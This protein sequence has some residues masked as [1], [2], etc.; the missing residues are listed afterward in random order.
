ML[1]RGGPYAV[2]SNEDVVSVLERLRSL[3]DRGMDLYFADATTN[4][5]NLSLFDDAFLSISVCLGNTESLAMRQSGFA[6][7]QFS[8]HESEV[9]SCQKFVDR[10]LETANLATNGY[11]DQLINTAK[12]CIDI[13]EATQYRSRS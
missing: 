4:E 11:V 7:I 5:A 10:F 13:K 9:W 12:E 8:S 2:W 1:F 3:M 6:R